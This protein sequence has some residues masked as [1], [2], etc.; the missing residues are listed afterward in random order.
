MNIRPTTQDAYELLHQGALALADVEANGIRID[1]KKLQENIEQ[2]SKRIEHLTTM[3][4][5]SDVWKVWKK[6]FGTD[7]NIDSP[8]QLGK[9]LFKHMDYT[10][11][12]EARTRTGRP[13]T[14]VETLSQ[15]NIDFVK[16][17]IKIKQL[18]KARDT[19]LR[20]IQRETVDGFMHPVFTLHLAR[21]FRGSS[22]HPNFQN[23]PVR[24][25]WIAKLIRSCYIARPNHHFVEV[26]YDGAEIRISTCN[27][28]DPHMISYI[29]NE[30]SDLHRDVSAEC[31]ICE[32]DQITKDARY[33]AKSRFVFPQFYGDWYKNCARGLWENID[34]MNL[35]LV[36]GT[37]IKEHLA[38]K[39]IK[40]LGACDKNQ[41][42]KSGT[43]EKHI[44]EVEH[45]FWY[46]L[47]PDYRE[48]KETH[49]AKY[50]KHGRFSM[51][52]G[53]TVEGLYGRKEVINYCI[54][55]PAFH[56]LLWSLI[57]L[58]AKMK[59][60]KMRSLIIGQIHDSIVADVH[61]DELDDFLYLSNKIMTQTIRHAWKWI[62]V[63]LKV[64]AEVAPLGGSWFDKE[65]VEI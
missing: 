6:V 57:K 4:K 20:G 36:N 18:K 17:Y 48:W 40:R 54:Q 52:T 50:Q 9:V 27:H 10:C 23:Q 21:S 2:T 59:R 16:R 53:F 45:R 24:V 55:G 12:D 15:L 58:N 29:E 63:P 56:C 31:Y 19:Y 60:L 7:A 37:P 51:L 44:E 11:P 43:F 32:A 28:K 14:D 33:S 39:G 30:S 8:D 38:R 42:P 62:I 25:D 47:F 65:K 64:E 26:D 35:T 34:S 46:D 3:I 49:W 5:R 22:D 1:T 61:K 13:K 41:K